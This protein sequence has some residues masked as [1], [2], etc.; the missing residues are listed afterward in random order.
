MLSSKFN[1][2]SVEDMS[3]VFAGNPFIEDYSFLQYI[4]TRNVKTMNSMF[5]CREDSTLVSD[6]SS[7]ANWNVEKV[8]DMSYLFANLIINSYLPFSNWAILL[9]Q[10][11]VGFTIG[12]FVCEKTKLDE[13]V[14]IKGIAATYLNKL[15][16]RTK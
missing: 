3:Y 11:I 7:V 10:I 13:Y 9:L 16:H 15:I 1:T 5:V 12:Y 6:F 2:S 14:E 4:D 8:E